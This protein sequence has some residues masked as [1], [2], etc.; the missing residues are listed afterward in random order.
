MEHTYQ[1][2]LNK[3]CIGLTQFYSILILSNRNLSASASLFNS[4]IL[5]CFWSFSC[6][7]LIYWNTCCCY[8]FLCRCKCTNCH[9]SN[10][11]RKKAMKNKSILNV[12]VWSNTSCEFELNFFFLLFSSILFCLPMLQMKLSSYFT[13]FL[14]KSALKVNLKLFLKKYVNKWLNAVHARKLKAIGNEQTGCI[15]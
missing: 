15:T 5:H 10:E 7:L 12:R 1:Q 14:S 13:F 9:F 2:Q 4:Y 3:V 8:C 11:S 6:F